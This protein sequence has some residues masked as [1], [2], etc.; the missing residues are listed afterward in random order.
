VRDT[1]RA[2]L[3]HGVPVHDRDRRPEMMHTHLR[4]EFELHADQPDRA[5][6]S[7]QGRMSV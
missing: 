3:E 4:D 7:G 6:R 1:F 2:F 5:G